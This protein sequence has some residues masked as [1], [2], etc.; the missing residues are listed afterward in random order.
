MS[1]EEAI[2]C[3]RCEGSG[4][5]GTCL[6]CKGSGKVIIVVKTCE[7]CGAKLVPGLN[8]QTAKQ[9]ACDACRAKRGLA[10]YRKKAATDARIAK[11]VAEKKIL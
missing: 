4:F 7:T 8:V 5:A 2:T 10:L 6:R 9:K 11:L 3:S 1:Y